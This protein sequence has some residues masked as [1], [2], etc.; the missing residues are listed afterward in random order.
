[1]KKKKK[2]KKK[3]S[4]KRTKEVTINKPISF[5]N[6]N[7]FPLSTSATILREGTIVVGQINGLC[8]D[9]E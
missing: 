9:L 6:V 3:K 2:K 4:S 1:M 8:D 7:R 5:T